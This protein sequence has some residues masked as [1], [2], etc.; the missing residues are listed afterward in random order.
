MR[1]FL[2]QFSDVIKGVFTAFDRIVFRGRIMPLNND[3]RS[4]A[5]P[6]S[7]MLEKELS[8]ISYSILFSPSPSASIPSR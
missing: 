1:S 4:C 3:A 6:A 2:V 8:C 5:F 7:L